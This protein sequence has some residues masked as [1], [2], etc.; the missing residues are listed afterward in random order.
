VAVRVV[1]PEVLAAVTVIFVGIADEACPTKVHMTCLKCDFKGNDIIPS[2]CTSSSS[3]SFY[4]LLELVQY[5]NL[6]D[7]TKMKWF[8]VQPLKC[9]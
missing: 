8:R 4:L 1:L 5:K 3:I 7:S 9:I 6:Y 2:V